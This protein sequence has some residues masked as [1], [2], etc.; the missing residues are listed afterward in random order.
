MAGFERVTKGTS[1]IMTKA[2][3]TQK[4]RKKKRAKKHLQIEVKDF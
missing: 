1:V 3:E 4:K 2:G